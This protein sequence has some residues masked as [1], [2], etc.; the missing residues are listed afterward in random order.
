MVSHSHTGETV[1]SPACLVPDR[2]RDNALLLMLA[3]LENLPLPFSPE[4]RRPGRKFHYDQRLFL[5]AAVI[6]TLKK[7]SKVYE[8]LTTIK[9]PTP[10]M[11]LL[12]EHL[13]YQQRMP[14]R[15][16]FER[17]LTAL[18]EILP[19]L[20][21]R[22]GALLVVL[23]SVWQEAGR[24]VAMDSTI[25]H[26][27]DKAV[28]HKKHQETGE[29]PHTRIDTEA[30]WTKSGWHGWI[31]GWKLHVTA[32]VGSVWIPV[33]ACLT[34]ANVHDGAMG[35]EM[36]S[37]LPS[38]TRFVLG[39]QHYR[40]EEMEA[41]CHRRGIELIATQAGK[42]PHTNPGVEV[43]RVFHQLRSKT[44]ENFN[45][46]FKAIFDSHCAV[47]TKG[48]AATARFALSAILVYQLGLWV[49]HEL[50]LPPHQG[51]KAFLRAV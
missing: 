26:A 40:T 9:E 21:A 36:V 27:K 3:L 31:Y 22:I 16:T 28:W 18:A 51:M 23:L 50:G 30:G 46:H 11:R 17:R 43:R 13:I 32:T 29:V 37:Q 20:I 35:Q 8:L 41:A 33:C 5:K 19:L 49:R 44:I 2:E 24:A 15:R 47:P 10:E 14:T 39:D 45:E 48:K 4:P 34:V 42:Y 1:S 38:Q 6:M 25:L 7:F 12:R